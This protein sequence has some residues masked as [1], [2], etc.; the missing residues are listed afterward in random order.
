VAYDGT[1]FSGWQIQNEDRTVQGAVQAALERMH[2]RVVRLTAAGR[3]DAGVHAT[4]QVA[5]F[6]TDIDSIPPERF[7][8][9]IN[10][11]LPK[12]VRILSSEEVP[13]SFHARRSAMLREYRYYILSAPVCPPH[14]RKYCFWT[15]RRLDIVRLN[16]MASLLEGEH[17]FTSFSSRGD[18]NRS[19][20][21]RIAVSSFHAEGRLL[22]YTIAA[23]SFL[24][25]M[26]RTIVG[27]FL[28]LEE[29]GQGA[30]ELKR[31]LETSSR[32][33]AGGTAAPRGLFL[34]R[35]V[36]ADGSHVQNRGVEDP[37]SL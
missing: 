4:G 2:G 36:Y 20:V 34:E 9:A 8:D 27:T 14:L 29:N 28:M 21:R 25:K 32:F 26:V 3:T 19:K 13:A 30:E 37:G 6:F 31:I 1:D 5:N 23:S 17:D 33:E 15:R 18:R 10:S 12:D 7:R 35:V 11:F 24:W 16:E 22:I